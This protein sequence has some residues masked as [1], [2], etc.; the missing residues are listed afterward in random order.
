MA[1]DKAPL[2]QEFQA[3]IPLAGATQDN[4][5]TVAEVPFDGTITGLSY[6]PDLA[7]TGAD[8]NT[9][10][11]SFG[12]KGQAGSGTVTS[13]TLALVSGVNLSAFVEKEFTLSGTA[14]D[15]MVAQGDIIVF[16]SLHVLTGIADPGGLVQVEITRG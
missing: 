1:N 12:N 5:T 14:S 8:S 3:R 11:L 6:T 9:R 2:V 13:A 7:V 4:I 16:K 15:L 10:T